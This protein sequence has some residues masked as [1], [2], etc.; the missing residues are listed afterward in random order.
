MAGQAYSI[1][2]VDENEMNRDLLTRRLER[3]GYQVTT[4]VPID[5]YIDGRLT[6]RV[7]EAPR[8]ETDAP[9]AEQ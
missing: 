5:E 9:T 4:A 1:L 7:I 6:T 3:Q 8:F 2:I